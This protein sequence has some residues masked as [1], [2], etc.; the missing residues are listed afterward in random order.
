MYTYL[1]GII[2]YYLV[3]YRVQVWVGLE[4]IW[5]RAN[6]VDQA[7]ILSSRK[8]HCLFDFLWKQEMMPQIRENCALSCVGFLRNTIS[9]GN[10][11][12]LRS[13]W[14]FSALVHSCTSWNIIGLAA[15]TWIFPDSWW[16]THENGRVSKNMSAKPILSCWNPDVC[17]LKH[18]QV[19]KD[20]SCCHRNSHEKHHFQESGEKWRCWKVPPVA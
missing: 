15:L 8:Q 13:P 14:L 20:P 1:S 5:T 9:P 2:M 4:D 16:N 11:L 3:I 7:N 12:S 10:L 18:L 19:C 17:L 6:Q